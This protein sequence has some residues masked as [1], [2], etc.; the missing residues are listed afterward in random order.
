MALE[1]HHPTKPLRDT[2][3]GVFVKSPACNEYAVDPAL[4]KRWHRP[5]VNRI[6]KDQVIRAIAFV[7][8]RVSED[9]AGCAI[10]T[11]ALC[12]PAS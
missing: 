1:R 9:S 4:K 12:V 5:P 11:G 7:T 6:D 10:T 2:A 8:A 3:F